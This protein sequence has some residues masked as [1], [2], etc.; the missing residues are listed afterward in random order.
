MLQN[1]FRRLTLASAAVGTLLADTIGVASADASPTKAT[2]TRTEC[3]KDTGDYKAKVCVEVNAT[4]L[5]SGVWR[6][7]SITGTVSD[8]EEPGPGGTFCF[9][10]NAHNKRTGTTAFEDECEYDNGAPVL[11]HKVNMREASPGGPEFWREY[12]GHVLFDV[13]LDAGGWSRP[14]VG[15][16]TLKLN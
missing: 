6:I 5:G 16:P 13:T 8:Q 14:D 15:R 2:E 12:T 9:L 11:K 7:N 1:R 10:L 4:N 3:V